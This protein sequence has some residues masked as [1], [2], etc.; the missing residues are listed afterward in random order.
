MVIRKNVKKHIRGT[1]VVHHDSNL[2]QP[3]SLE[4]RFLEKIS[5]RQPELGEFKDIF[6]APPRTKKKYLSIE[7]KVKSI[8]SQRN[9][10]LLGLAEK[11]FT[12]IKKRDE[13]IPKKA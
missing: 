2:M 9:M 12:N 1:S 13:D 4:Q 8:R 7:P 10:E 6:E 11:Q 3:S 5:E